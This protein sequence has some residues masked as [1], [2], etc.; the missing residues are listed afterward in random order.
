LSVDP[1]L[2]GW[3]LGSFRLGKSVRNDL[4]AKV[5]EA[6]DIR[7]GK[8]VWLKVLSPIYGGK[9]PVVDCFRKQVELSKQITHPGLLEEHFY[10][11]DQG[12]YYTVA[13]S[14]A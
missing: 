4:I 11:N 10:S 5:Y 6:T 8:V 2:T 1:N 14:L 9:T 7:D 13:L 3:T 12:F